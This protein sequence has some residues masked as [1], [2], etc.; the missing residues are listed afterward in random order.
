MKEKD[1]CWMSH[2]DY[3]SKVPKGFKIIATTDE[4]PCAAMENA[5]KK[6]YGVQFH[7]EVEHTLFG[8]KCLRTFCLTYVI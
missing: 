2:T 4:C 7:P 5:E 8:K 6:L 1:Q 3:I